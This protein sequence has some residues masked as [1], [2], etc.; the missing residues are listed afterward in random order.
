M[1]TRARR[2]TSEDQAIEV[3]RTIKKWGAVFAVVGAGA[4]AWYDARYQV[5]SLQAKL[6]ELHEDY[7]DFRRAYSV[8]HNFGP[9]GFVAPKIAAG[10]EAHLTR[11]LKVYGSLT[12]AEAK[13]WRNAF[14]QLNP[15]LLRPTE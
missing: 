9:D 4:G 1:R 14:F 6:R 12:H 8:D 3:L 13:Q 11:F 7:N 2:K 10:L 15:S 5:E